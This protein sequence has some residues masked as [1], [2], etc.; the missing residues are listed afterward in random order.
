MIRDW[1]T[2][3]SITSVEHSD[4][5]LSDVRRLVYALGLH[6]AEPRSGMSV[7]EKEICRRIFWEAYVIDKSVK[8]LMLLSA[9]ENLSYRTHALDGH[10]ILIHDV[11][12]VPPLPAEVDDERFSI[13]AD[14]VSES[15]PSHPPSFMV[16]FVMI[17]KLFQWIY[18]CLWRHRCLQNDLSMGY[19]SKDLIKWAVEIKQ[20]LDNAIAEL[21]SQL[22]STHI[23][24]DEGYSVFGMQA[25]NI[26]ITA[27]C[28]EL[29]LV[30]GRELR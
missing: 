27:L 19:D 6:R 9:S 15:S 12:G 13:I 21:P 5:L 29:A 30:S 18:Q 4:N 10:G 8:S 1:I 22:R 2:G 7:I 20:K 3:Q 23:L 28:L 14:A 17:A 25:A 26:C 16:G 24:P 11:D